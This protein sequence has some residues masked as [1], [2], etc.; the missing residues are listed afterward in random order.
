MFLNGAA[1]I[2]EIA[3]PLRLPVSLVCPRPKSKPGKKRKCTSKKRK[4]KRERSKK[5]GYFVWAMVVTTSILMKMS[6]GFS[7]LSANHGFTED[8]T[9]RVL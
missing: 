6:A 4:L 1:Q 2:E 5:E 3:L 7:A 8:V 9:I